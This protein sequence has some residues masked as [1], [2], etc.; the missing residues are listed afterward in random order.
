MRTHINF[1]V[2]ASR[3]HPYTHHS[4]YT[5]KIKLFPPNLSLKREEGLQGR[6]LYAILKD[7]L[8]TAIERRYIEF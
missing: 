8:H 3:T 6:K 1:S 7:R 4:V 2:Y 5:A